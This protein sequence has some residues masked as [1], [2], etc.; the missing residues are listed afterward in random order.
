M[1]VSDPPDKQSMRDILSAIRSII[2]EEGEAAPRAN[3][4][5]PLSEALGESAGE[6]FPGSDAANDPLAPQHVGTPAASS[7]RTVEELAAELMRPMLKQ[8]I[9]AHLHDL[10]ER[11]VAEEVRRV[12]R[13]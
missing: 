12:T 9:D 10:V 7:G 5:I 3:P 2:D 4:A 6:A 11:M 1:A 13:R 8:W